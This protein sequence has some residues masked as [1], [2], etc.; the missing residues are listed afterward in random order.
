V[1]NVEYFDWAATAGSFLTLGS[2][3]TAGLA[4]G[5]FGERYGP[6]LGPAP[7]AGRRSATAQEVVA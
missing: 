2:W 5:L 7:A 6:H 4:L 3:A 1:R